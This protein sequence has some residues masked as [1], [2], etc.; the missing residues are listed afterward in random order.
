MEVKMVVGHFYSDTVEYA[1]EMATL[2]Q[3]QGYEIAYENGTI[4]NFVVMKT[5]TIEEPNV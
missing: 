2:L 5:V 3:A 1:N 4:S